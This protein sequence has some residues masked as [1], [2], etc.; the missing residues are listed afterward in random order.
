[1]N[2]IF[3]IIIP[4]YNQGKYLRD[5]L[6]S[7]LEQLFL[8]WECI[9]VNDG[10]DDDTSII[11]REYCN[12]DKR[13]QYFEKENGGLS[14][15]R[16]YGILHS[17][18]EFILPLDADDKIHH[19]YLLLASQIY[20]NN[21][22]TTLVYCDADLFGESTSNWILPEYDYR[23]LLLKNSI[24]CS[25]I[26]KKTDWIKVGGYDETLKKGWEDW[27]FWI[28][29][30][31]KDSIVYK[32][33]EICFFYRIKNHSMVKDMTEQDYFRINWQIFEKHFIKYKYNYIPPQEAYSKI[34]SLSAENESLK[35]KISLLNNAIEDIKKSNSYKIG[36]IFVRIYLYF[37][38]R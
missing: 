5:A 6:D 1:M 29:I 18:G 25:A 26:F 21:P 34:S 23:D 30:L 14:S 11:S 31:D 7:V 17:K 12:K 38:L 8:D 2:I 20:F 16:N 22:K 4:C 28:S 13:I 32:I 24:F 3:S 9:I 36:N 35:E 19:H 33:P 37:K 27:E 15:A 10:S